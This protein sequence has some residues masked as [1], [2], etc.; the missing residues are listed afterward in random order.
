MCPSVLNRSSFKE[1]HVPT[2]F[3]KSLIFHLLPFVFNSWIRAN[4]SCILVVL[5][6]NASMQDQTVKLNDLQV[7][8]LM[9]RN[10][11]SL[12][13]VEIRNINESKNS[14]GSRKSEMQYESLGS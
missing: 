9:V 11:E 4:E 3:N 5:H 14:I 10:T 2:D 6:L 8:S 7:K 1:R 13:E 12:S